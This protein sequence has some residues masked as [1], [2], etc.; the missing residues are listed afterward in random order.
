M[1]G[2]VERDV[3]VAFGKCFD[4]DSKRHIVDEGCVVVD[5]GGVKE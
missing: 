2:A 3:A 1:G 5:W 4:L